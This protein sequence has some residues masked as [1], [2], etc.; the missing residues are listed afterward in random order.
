[1]PD[2]PESPVQPRPSFSTTTTDKS[3]L[4]NPSDQ[5]HYQPY[6]PSSQQSGVSSLPSVNTLPS[7]N[8]NTTTDSS[9]AADRTPGPQAQAGRQSPYPESKNDQGRSTPG[10]GQKRDEDER[11]LPQKHDELCMLPALG[12]IDELSNEI[13]WPNTPK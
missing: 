13:Q 12:I 5:P 10:P 6:R 7:V 4:I 1:M 8:N 2:N 3:P 9:M 11:S